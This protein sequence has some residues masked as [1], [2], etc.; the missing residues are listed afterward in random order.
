[1]LHPV[2]QTRFP[3][4]SHTN[5]ARIL[6]LSLVFRPDNVSTAQI[7][8]D[9]AVDFKARGHEVFVITTVPHYN[10]DPVALEKQPLQR[11]WGKLLQKSIYCG[12]QVWHAWMP[13][14][15]R[16]KLL[17]ILAWIGFHLIT[18]MAGLGSRFKPDIIL[19]PSPPLT[20]GVSAWLLGL[21]HHCPFIYNVQEI[22]PDVAVNLG[23]FKSGFII[24][25]LLKLERFV[26]AKAKALAII[27]EG[28]AARIHAKN[29]PPDKICIIPN[30]VDINDF[31]PLPKVNHFSLQHGL[32][33]KF[34]VSYA[35]NMGKPQGL[36]A[37]LEAADIVRDMSQIHFLLMGDGSERTHLIEKAHHLQLPNITILPYQPYHLMAEAYAAADTSFVSQAP[38]TSSDGIPSKVYRI[39]ACARP[40]IAC[41]DLDSDLARLLVKAGGGVVVPSGDAKK[42]A[43]AIQQAFLQRDVWH[44]N[45]IKARNFIIENYSRST[46]SMRYNELIGEIIK[47][48]KEDKYHGRHRGR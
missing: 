9:L 41:T 26:Y 28:M 15:G 36:D 11:C 18:T 32:R 29:I 42:L 3:L 31:R 12:M 46:I 16:N 22:Y 35:G 23:V 33:D 14:K 39:M 27:S 48:C 13:R 20:I 4:P 1:M 7:M 45:G 34:V 37:L 6:I 40:V 25:L 19:A 10:N 5:M 38:G 44:E 30:F 47:V 2:L 17:R 8:G 21:R 24:G 43:N